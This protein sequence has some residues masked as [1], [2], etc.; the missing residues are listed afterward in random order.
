MINWIISEEDVLSA[1]NAPPEYTDEQKL[2][3]LRKKYQRQEGRADKKG[4]NVTNF[5]SEDEYVAL[6]ADPEYRC[7]ITGKT[8]YIHDATNPNARLYYW[9]MTIDHKDPLR[10]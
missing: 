6:V 2:E 1:I 3:K 10:K 5:L 8:T 4:S 9:T 7:V